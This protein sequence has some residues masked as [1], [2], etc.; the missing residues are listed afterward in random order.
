MLHLSSFPGTT[1]GERGPLKNT[2]GCHVGSEHEHGRKTV[3]GK[4]GGLDSEGQ[5]HQKA[6]TGCFVNAGSVLREEGN[7]PGLHRLEERKVGEVGAWES[8]LLSPDRL[9]HQWA[10]QH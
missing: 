3:A 9:G 10:K 1:N 4:A 7:P 5:N 2:R 6:W 8:L